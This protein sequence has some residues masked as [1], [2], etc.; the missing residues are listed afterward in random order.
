MSQRP[1]V[2]TI[3]GGG[4][5]GWLTAGLLAAQKTSNGA[6]AFEVKL[7]EPENISGVGVGEGTWPSMRSTLRRIGVSE[8]DFLRQTGASFKQGTKFINWVHNQGET[9][10]HPFDRPQNGDG[11]EDITVLEAWK[12]SPD[13]LPFAQFAGVQEALCETYTSPKLLTSR[14]YSGVTNYGYHFEADAMARFLK[15]HCQ[16]KLSVTVIP[17]IMTDI[18]SHENGDIRAVMTK[19]HGEIAGDFFIDC[20]GFRSLLHKQHF[21]A[22]ITSLKNIFLSDRALVARVP[23]HEEANIESTTHSAAQRAGWIWDVGLAKRFGVGYVHSGAHVSQNEAHDTLRAYLENKGYNPETLSFREV[24]FDPNYTQ[25]SWINNCAA[26]GLSAGFVEPLEASSIMLTEMAACELVASFMAADY[27][28]DKMAARFNKTFKSRW[29]QVIHFLKLHYVL[30]RRE[31]PFWR[32]SRNPETIPSALADDLIA[33]ADNAP[34]SRGADDLFPAESYQFILHGMTHRP[35]AMP[36]AELSLLAQYQ[37]RL[38]QYMKVLA[39]NK[40]WL[41]Y[42]IG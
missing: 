21:K 2:M 17:D 7:I 25:T 23:Y 13:K 9:Y 10:Y 3:V 38:R 24:K 5:A 14:D 34:I 4:T 41:N 6:P 31:D 36:L 30:S 11:R 29:E 19:D 33:W 15:Q 16:E 1:K 20:T 12:N 40:D 8:I 32:D 27:S 28:R 35:A 26:I 22:R 18:V 39:T 42:H 37:P